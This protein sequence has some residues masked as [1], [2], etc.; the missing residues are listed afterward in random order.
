MKMKRYLF[1]L[2][3]AAIAA[4]SCAKDADI[5]TG[6]ASES[7]MKIDAILSEQTKTV[8]GDT[9]GSTLTVMFTSNDKLLVYGQN[10]STI[11]GVPFRPVEDGKS[12]TKT[13]TTDA[14]PDGFTPIYA[15]AT[16]SESTLNTCTEDGVIKML[17]NNARQ[18]LDWSNS[19]ASNSTTHVGKIENGRVFLKNVCSLIGFRI[20]GKNDITKI[21][22]RGNADEDL[23]GWI[24]V[25]YSKIGTEEQFY[26]VTNGVK[27]IT[28]TAADDIDN[29]TA[30]GGYIP[31]DTDFF[32]SLLPGT[33]TNGFTITMTDKDG[34]VAQRMIETSVTLNRSKARLLS[35]PVNQGLDFKTVTLPEQISFKF[36]TKWPFVESVV[37]KDSQSSGGDDYTYDYSDSE[38]GWSGTFPFTICK[39]DSYSQTQQ[40]LEFSGTNSWIRLPAIEGRILKSVTAK[41]RNSSNKQFNISET[42]GGT[43]MKSGSVKSGGTLTLS[44]SD[45][46]TEKPQAGVSYYLNIPSSSTYCTEIIIVYGI[47]GG[48][49]EY[50][51]EF[52]VDVNLTSWPFTPACA[53]AASQSEEG[54]TYSYQFTGDIG[55]KSYSFPLSFGLCKG[56][57]GNTYSITSANLLSFKRVGSAAPY[58]ENLGYIKLPAVPGRYLKSV[59]LTITT[60]SANVYICKTADRVTEG[61][62]LVKTFKAYKTTD[63]SSGDLTNTDVNTSYYLYRE[64]TTAF[65][66][67]NLKL[68]YATPEN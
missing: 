9:E 27:K 42:A 55:G 61:E 43:A 64:S 45:S 52:T 16:T 44:W 1:A 17:V 4:G 66:L 56:P 21:E 50:P 65:N 38:S 35:T 30:T 18:K 47:D 60:T 2:S 39:G 12:T 40:S 29:G 63:T 23:G 53:D 58:E 7:R 34:K 36:G 33:Y 54:E 57:N 5:E 3:V 14:W 28:V 15:V 25:D 37:A 51:A 67:N 59:N 62:N 26:T 49:D 24:S 13:F 68:T 22:L 32:I 6:T 10:E 20:S 8:I 19:Y 31:E 11:Q 46:D 41:V 48:G